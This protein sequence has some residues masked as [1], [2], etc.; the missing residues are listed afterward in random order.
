MT[1]PYTCPDCG[2]PLDLEE[3]CV[4][5]EPYFPNPRDD[6]HLHIHRN[7][8]LPRRERVRAVALCTGCEFVMEVE[9]C[10]NKLTA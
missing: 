4:V 6:R 2:A 8:S 1:T 10:A 7:K 3:R 9:P 5:S